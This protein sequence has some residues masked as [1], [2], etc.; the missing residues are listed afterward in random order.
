MGETRG[1][2]WSYQFLEIVAR[3]RDLDGG[4]AQPPHH[5]FNSDE[6][7]LIFSFGVRVVEPQ[8]GLP[9][10]MS[11]KAEIYRNPTVDWISTSNGYSGTWMHARLGMTNMEEACGEL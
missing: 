11:R 1:T 7:F 2:I 5:L 8:V 9:A 3:V 6:V 10:V 4:E